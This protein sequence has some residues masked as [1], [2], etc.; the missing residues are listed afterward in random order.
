MTFM[1]LIKKRYSVRNFKKD[2]V[3]DEF[4]KQILEAGRLAPTGA[5]TQPQ[6]LIVVRERDGL[7]KL[8]KAGT[9]YDAP[10]AI[11]VCGDHSKVWKRPFDGKLLTD[12]DTSIVTDHM[13]L[14]ATDLGLGSVWILYFKP[15]VIKTDFNIPDFIEPIH[16]LAIG[17]EKEDGLFPNRPTGRK[18]LEDTVFGE[19][20]NQK[21]KF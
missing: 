8:K 10:L 11:I 2:P 20:Y 19:V 15:D 4:I 9:I 3:P 13:M 6:R 17:Y 14:E 16:I 1:D 21:L 7:D 5:N 12:I 18:P